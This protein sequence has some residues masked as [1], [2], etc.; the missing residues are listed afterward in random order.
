MQPS[1]QHPSSHLITSHEHCIEQC[2]AQQSGNGVDSIM[3]LYVYRGKAHK[4]IKRQKNKEQPTVASMPRKENQHGGNTD[5][6]AGERR[7]GSLA[8]FFGTLDKPVEKAVG[9]SGTW[10]TV[11]MGVEIVAHCRENA[12]GYILNAHGF[13]IERRSGDGNKDKY[14]IVDEERR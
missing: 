12:I 5:M 9:F 8:G 11:G 1:A 13:I 14:H 2:A 10:K 6:T 7:R 3:S 4:S